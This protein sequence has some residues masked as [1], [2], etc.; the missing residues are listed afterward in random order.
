MNRSDQEQQS[1]INTFK[2][3]AIRDHQVIFKQGTPYTEI[4]T[5]GNKN[6]S[7]NCRIDYILR[8]GS[9]CV[10]GDLGSAVYRW[11]NDK[12][13]LE[14]IAGCNF[15]YFYGKNEAGENGARASDWDSDLAEREIK[16]HI[17][18]YMQDGSIPTTY[19]K[20]EYEAKDELKSLLRACGNKNE[21]DAYLIS[22]QPDIAVN[23]DDWWE[24]LPSVGNI[25][26]IRPRM[27]L[28]GLK[29]AVGV[30]IDKHC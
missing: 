8:N 20:D 6:G 17:R 30:E 9:L 12:L 21:F 25:A 16:T 4:M 14:W 10:Y 1:I 3:H 18:E 22:E 24:W 26:P 13:T 11:Y 28:I 27:H 15:G 23:D 19:Y 29:M 2:D 7:S 5:W